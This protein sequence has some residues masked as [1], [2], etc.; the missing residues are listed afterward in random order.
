M[1]AR[2]DIDPTPLPGHVVLRRK[3]ITDHRGFFE[4]LYCA[5]DLRDAG[6]TAPIAQINRSLT[7]TRG[8]L[9]GL[10]LQ[11]PPSAETKIVT[12]LTGAVFDVAVDLRPQSPAFRKWHATVLAADNARTVVIPAG[13]AH[14]FQTLADDSSLLYFHTAPHDPAAERGINPFDPE[15][16]IHWPETIA[17]LSDRD[18]GLPALADFLKEFPE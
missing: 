15:L 9:R 16:A 11:V 14:G 4:R 5:D 6:I 7:R 10:H 8:S 13:F 12:C 1:A 3:P 17:D 2:F 18:R